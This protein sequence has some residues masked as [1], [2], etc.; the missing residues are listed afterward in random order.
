[1]FILT[2]YNNKKTCQIRKNTYGIIYEKSRVRMAWPA[3]VRARAQKQTPGS[4][5][6]HGN[7]YLNHTFPNRNRE[8]HSARRT[9]PAAILVTAPA[10]ILTENQAIYILDKLHNAL[11][12]KFHQ[13]ICYKTCFALHKSKSYLMESSMHLNLKQNNPKCRTLYYVQKC[14][15]VTEY[16]VMIN[17]ILWLKASLDFSFI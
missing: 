12:R 6:S 9:W 13:T 7:W 2:W 8:Y 10:I 14:L 16:P 11:E 17:V 15:I 1:M 4:G 5:V 3:N